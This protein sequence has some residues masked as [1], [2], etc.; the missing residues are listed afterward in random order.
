MGASENAKVIAEICHWYKPNRSLRFQ[1]LC[2]N[3]TCTVSL[4]RTPL[5]II[6]GRINA[7]LALHHATVI[8]L[9]PLSALVNFITSLNPFLLT[10]LGGTLLK[11]RPVSSILKIRY[12]LSWLTKFHTDQ[13]NHQPL[14]DSVP[15]L[16]LLIN[17]P[18]FSVQCLDFS[19][20]MKTNPCPHIFCLYTK[21]WTTPRSLL[22]EM[23]SMI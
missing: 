8:T 3:P 21:G 15:A 10:I 9:S 20:N 18:V 12:A 13:N 17:L 4:K 23:E 22:T 7:S 19:G 2:L 1:I 6:K 11:G 16:L 5:S 14:Y